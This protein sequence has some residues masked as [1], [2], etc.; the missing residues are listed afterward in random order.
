MAGTTI[1]PS[2]PVADF[3]NGPLYKA[4]RFSTE[5]AAV[6]PNFHRLYNAIGLAGG[7]LLGRK[8]MDIM[9]G[10]EPDGT[11][12]ERQ[13]VPMVL[14]PLHGILPYD[15]F[16]DDPKERWM[17]VFDRV[18][19]AVVGAMGASAGS[20]KFF[21]KS[22]IQPA[23]AKLTVAVNNPEAFTMSDAARQALYHQSKPWSLLTGSSALFGSASG[24]GLFP[25]IGHYGADLGT[26]FAIRSE[27][28]TAPLGRLVNSNMYLP[29]RPHAL[30][31]N[32]IEHM[33]MNPAEH[34]QQLQDYA[35]GVLKTWFRDV[36]PEQI[37]AFTQIVH[38]E[39]A[40]FLAMGKDPAQTQKA[41]RDGL[42]ELIGETGIEKTLGR[43]GLDPREASIGDTGFTSIIGRIIGDMTGMKTSEKIEETWRQSVRG[44]EKRNPAL[45]DKPFDV[46]A[47]K[48]QPDR[49]QKLAATAAMGVGVAGLGLIST[50]KDT[51]VGDITDVPAKTGTDPVLEK[52]S[53]PVEGHHHTLHS[54]QEHGFVNGKLLDAAEGVTDAFNVVNG[55]NSHRLYCAVGLSAGSWVA[56]EFMKAVTGV[57]FAG[58]AVAKADIQEP[59]Q[60]FYKALPF[61]PHSDL[62]NDK[63][64]Q[65]MR[66]AV[67][68]AVGCASIVTASQMYFHEREKKLRDAKYLDDVEAKATSEQAAPWTVSTALSALFGASSGF[69][70]VPG[71]NYM[72][73]LGTRYSMASGRKVS[74]PGLGKMW[75]NNSTLYPFAPPGMIDLVIKEAVNNKSHDPELLET[76]AIGVLKPWFDKVT[77][78]QVEAFVN[79]VYEIRD[80]YYRDGGVPEE[81]KKD[82][83]AQLKAHL[84]GAGLEETLESIGLSPLSATIA[85]NGLSGRISEAVGAKSQVDKIRAEYV[86]GYRERHQQ[87]Q[88]EA[89]E[90]PALPA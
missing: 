74:M 78:E 47:H 88:Q 42:T 35:H 79:Q 73:H 33:A 77:P 50:A 81:Y 59:F 67:P 41:I 48:Y 5:Y 32:M 87:R 44:M 28:S 2:G 23:E 38:D 9:V 72:T 17:C 90:G 36:T 14:R 57:S 26:L 43:I 20:A 40:K 18:V 1:T 52:Y 55:L 83:E 8:L 6:P 16:S 31:K 12:V 68:M 58:K 21:S 30:L 70:W 7:L 27:R 4:A 80:Q 11:P 75:S 69:A 25:S 62:P 46:N 54:K 66:W 49:A 45:K 76:Y 86:A 71:I 64:M 22:F 13:D 37:D 24:F 34:P 15:H 53:H 19:P 63:W 60:K 39:R 56:E 3:V 84:K 29:L 82:L 85:N 51:D 61:N 10:Q 65:V 89:G